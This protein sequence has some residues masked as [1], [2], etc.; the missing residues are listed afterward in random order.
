MFIILEAFSAQPFWGFMETSLHNNNWLSH[1]V[2]F[3]SV[4]SLSHVQ[5]FETPWTTACQASLSITS[6]GSLPKLVSIE[7]VMS[8][9]DLILCSH[10]LL[11]P[12]I[13]PSIRVF[14]NDQLFASGGQCFGASTS[15]SVLPVNIQDWFHLG[16]TGLISLQSKRFSRVFSNTTVWKHQF[17]GPQLSLWSNSHTDTWLLE[18]LY[19]WLYGLSLA[20]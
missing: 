17:F 16:L 12:S 10:P 8:F 20:K 7:L 18:K 19:L 5:L 1:L 13:F 14:S 4:Q 15:A 11:L 6:S 3:S 2:Q 9:N